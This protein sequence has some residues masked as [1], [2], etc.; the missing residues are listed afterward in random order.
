MSEGIL[1][2]IAGAGGLDWPRIL[3]IARETL[4]RL[5][6]DLEP[7][8]WL[9][10]ERAVDLGVEGLDP[11][12]AEAAVRMAV[13]GDLGGIPL[14]LVAQPR[15]GRR[16][17]L[18]VADMESTIIANEMLNELAEILGLGPSI[19]EVTRRAMAGEI[20]FAAAL[21]E[22]V[23][24]LRGFPVSALDDAAGRIRITPGA[25]EL[26]ATMRAAGAYTV[27]VSGGFRQFTALVRVRLGF[28]LDIANT[29][30][31][32]GD[33]IAG[34]VAEP[35]LGRDAKLAALSALAAERSLTLEET[36]AVGDG[37]N[38]LAMLEAAGLGVAYHAKPIADEHA[39]HRI[40]HADL[41]AL[42]YAQ[43]FRE[44]EIRRA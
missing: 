16:K 9:A 26:V 42:L 40:R 35:V 44:N 31:T 34:S 19:A 18:L 39:R 4:K 27:L 20:D 14:D 23:A 12:Q 29:L 6:A 30:V 13:A 24:L 32:M 3:D 25:A 43:G 11:D 8:D 28:D 15:A 37:A 38:D 41:T 33:R 2:L 10:A 7:V 36:L 5:G 21:R 17:R 1:T 22:R